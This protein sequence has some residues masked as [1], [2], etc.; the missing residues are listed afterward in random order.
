[1][2][3]QLQKIKAGLPD[4]FRS[5]LIF[6]IEHQ[7]RR[8][9]SASL[10]VLHLRN[11]LERTVAKSLDQ[12]LGSPQNQS[13]LSDLERHWNKKGIKIMPTPVFELSKEGSP[14]LLAQ[15]LYKSHGMALIKPAPSPESLSA[16]QPPRCS[17]H[18]R[19]VRASLM[20][21]KEGSFFKF[22]MN[23]T[24]QAPRSDMIS[25][26]YLRRR[27]VIAP[28]QRGID[29][30]ESGPG[31]AVHVEHG[32][33]RW[34]PPP[35]PPRGGGA[36][37]AAVAQPPSAAA[38]AS[39]EESAVVGHERGGVSGGGGGGGGA[40]EEPRRGGARGLVHGRH[41]PLPRGSRPPRARAS[42]NTTRGGDG[43]TEPDESCGGKDEEEDRGE[44]ERGE[45]D[46]DE[47]KRERE[48]EGKRMGANHTRLLSRLPPES[49]R[50][51][52]KEK[53][54]G[55]AREKCGNE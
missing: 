4:A 16:P 45:E 41:V 33:R 22:A 13:S 35:P 25:S 5:R 20:I 36:A 46:E 52:E 18:P 51:R 10:L 6:M 49:I 39:D 19:A 42:T 27:R 34:R 55:R 14:C 47:E 32:P 2:A 17:M 44:R 11:Q 3:N 26:E 43:G 15:L 40:E 12:L 29:R 28:L 54:R 8:K 21:L 50:K 7:I 48:R 53:G 1:M 38:G 23:P 31:G 9:G 24:P 30:G 37:T